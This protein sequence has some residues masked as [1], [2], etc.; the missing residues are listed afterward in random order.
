MIEDHCGLNDQDFAS[1]AILAMDEVL[2]SQ[3]HESNTS[4]FRKD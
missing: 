2:V 4:F 1:E 3:G